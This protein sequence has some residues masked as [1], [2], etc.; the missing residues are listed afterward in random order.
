MVSLND[1][2]NEQSI[3]TNGED[4]NDALDRLEAYLATGNPSWRAWGKKRK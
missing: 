3:S 2:D 4:V 1:A